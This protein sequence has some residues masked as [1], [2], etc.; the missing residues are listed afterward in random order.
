MDGFGATESKCGLG[1]TAKRFRGASCGVRA[2]IRTHDVPVDA[3]RVERRAGARHLV[4]AAQ[5]VRALDGQ[6]NVPDSS[7]RDFTDY[8]HDLREA[9]RLENTVEGYVKDGP[10][11]HRGDAASAEPVDR[12]WIRLL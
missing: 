4:A 8:P 6:E 2:L 12:R 11:D 1:D 7:A 5:V 3:R 10:I 9:K